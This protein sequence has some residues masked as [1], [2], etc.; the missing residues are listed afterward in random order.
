[1]SQTQ[2]RRSSQVD[3]LHGPILKSLLLFALPIMA[4]RVFQQIYNTM[5]TLIVGYTL[6]DSS[7]AAM[8][9]CSSIYE[10]MTGF[11]FGVG[12]GL[13]IVTARCFGRQETDRMKKSVASCIV[14][15]VAVTLVVTILAT[16][17]MHPLLRLR[18]GMSGRSTEFPHPLRRSPRTQLHPAQTTRNDLIIMVER[19]ASPAAHELDALTD[20][21]ERS[22]RVT[23]DFLAPEDIPFFRRMVRQEAL[24]AAEIYVIRDSGNGFAAFAGIGADR[25]EMLFVAPSARG[26]GLGRELVEHVAVHCG[27]RRVDVNEQNAQAAGFY[28][29]M[30]FRIV[31]RDALDPSGRPYPILH[32]ER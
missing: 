3:L 15:G 13:A 19:L 14:I 24:P 7:I 10:M 16:I 28:A 21:W 30:G 11:T 8:G 26:K 4:S 2:T 32:L 18:Q 9:A 6:G 29:R 27:V 25:L 1:M 17:F 22:V 20:L 5:D 12:N 31:S 23:H